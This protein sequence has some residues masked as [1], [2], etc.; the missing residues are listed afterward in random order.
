M[1]EAMRLQ[2]EE[3]AKSAPA[4]QSLAHLPRAGVGSEL[5]KRLVT[6]TAEIL[7]KKETSTPSKEL[8][9]L[10]ETS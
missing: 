3:V 8:V 10:D 1:R 9:G 6:F 2:R 4:S 7:R 5:G